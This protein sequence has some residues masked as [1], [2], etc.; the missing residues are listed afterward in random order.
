[1][2]DR[3]Q[4]DGV[5][6]CRDGRIAEVGPAGEVGFQPGK[7]LAEP[8]KFL[9][10]NDAVKVE[11]LVPKPLTIHRVICNALGTTRSTFQ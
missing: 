5:V 8:P 2:V 11:R 1:M 10:R 4:E 6:V 3:V 9:I 7:G